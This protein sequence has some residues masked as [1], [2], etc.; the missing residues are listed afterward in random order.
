MTVSLA[1][2][3]SSKLSQGPLW[4]P[5]TNTEISDNRYTDS[6]SG[7]V[8]LRACIMIC[9]KREE[10]NVLPPFAPPDGQSVLSI[11]S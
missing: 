4:L 3:C 7:F 9:M 1:T 10:K 2:A 11:I 8:E 6:D 5:E